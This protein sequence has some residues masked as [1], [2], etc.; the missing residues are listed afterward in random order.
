M[1]VH[2]SKN[3]RNKSSDEYLFNKEKIIKNATE[4]KKSLWNNIRTLNKTTIKKNKKINKKKRI[5]NTSLTSTEQKIYKNR[6]HIEHTFSHVKQSKLMN[7][8][9][10]TKEM[11]INKIYGRFI[12]FQIIRDTK[13]Q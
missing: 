7:I 8:N 1:H 2:Y 9:V 4:R 12:D 10:R 3:S 6:L 5:F 13:I 11:L